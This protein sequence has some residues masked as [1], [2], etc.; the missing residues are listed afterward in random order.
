MNNT[1]VRISK[2]LITNNIGSGSPV[3]TTCTCISIA[4]ITSKIGNGSQVHRTGMSTW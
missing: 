2:A 3:D 4:K 1:P